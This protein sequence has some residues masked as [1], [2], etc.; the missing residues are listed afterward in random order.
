MPS[1]F[2]HIYKQM[3]NCSELFDDG[4]SGAPFFIHH[5]GKWTL[6]IAKRSESTDIPIS[7]EK[8]LKYPR[9]QQT[10][11]DQ[12]DV[13]SVKRLAVASNELR[14]CRESLKQSIDS[15]TLFWRG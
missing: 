1:G 8:E 11:N 6:F 2:F 15:S 12:T 9:F 13:I 10:K 4:L 7:W 14:L 5:Y 3:V